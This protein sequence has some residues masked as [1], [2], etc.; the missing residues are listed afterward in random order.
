[1]Y[2]EK[3]EGPVVLSVHGGPGGYDQSLGLGEAFRANGFKIIGVSRPG[4]LGTP[5]ETGRS[6]EE[7]ADA[8]AALIDALELGKVAVIGASAGGPASYLLAARHPDKVAALI[9]IDAVARK[10]EI[11]VSWLE[12]KL[13]LS[14]AGLWLVHFLLDHFP[15]AM[16]KG[17][18]ETE[19]TLSGQELTQRIKEIVKDE[20]KFAWLRFLISTMSEKMDRRKAGLENDLKQLAALEPLPVRTIACPTLIFHGTADKD[21][22]PAHAEYASGAIPNSELYWIQDGSHLGFWTAATASAAQEYAVRW[23]TGQVH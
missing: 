12:E 15:E 18:L 11:Q 8:L 13:Y 23:L 21:V 2:G 22:V 3:G 4:Y 7:Q 5:L 1:E 17:F 9:E 16:V 10:Y 20:Y 6:Y 14:K 19:S